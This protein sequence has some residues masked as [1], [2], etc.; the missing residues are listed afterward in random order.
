MT[1]A[2]FTDV[3]GQRLPDI[4]V[5][6]MEIPAQMSAGE[7]AVVQGAATSASASLNA[8]MSTNFVVNLLLTGSLSQL[9]SMLNSQ[10]VMVYTPL[11]KNVKF[12]ANAMKLNEGLISVATFDLVDTQTLLDDRIFSMPEEEDAYTVNFEQCNIESTHTIRN[13]SIILW[14]YAI[15]FFVWVFV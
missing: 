6:K 13:L 1:L 9:W 14:I 15:N 12:P 2:Q 10:Q 11:F 4:V 8:A 5:S 3:Y 7:A